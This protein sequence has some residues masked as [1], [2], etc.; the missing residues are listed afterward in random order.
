MPKTIN[1]NATVTLTERDMG[2]FL[3]M[4]RYEGCTVRSW[5]HGD[6]DERTR[7]RPFDVVLVS[8]KPFTPAR[9][10]SFG[11]TLSGFWEGGR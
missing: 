6:G 5:N 4:L 3:D 10:A 8:D 1:H 2:A 11:L 7:T 9:W